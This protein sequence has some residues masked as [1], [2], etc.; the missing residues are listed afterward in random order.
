MK[1]LI[2]AGTLTAA[3]LLSGIASAAEYKVDHEGAHASIN[4]KIQHL[5]YSWLT[6]RFNHFSGDFNYDKDSAENSEIKVV[7]QI[8][9]LDSNHAERDK[10]L[11]GEKFLEADK[12]PTASFSSS[13]YQPSDANS[14]ILTGTLQLHGVSKSISFPIHKIGE[15]ADPWGGYRAGFSGT[16][17]LKLAD[18]GIDYDLG[19]ASTHV[20]MELHIEGVRQ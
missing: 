15:G 7:I 6:G 17:L 3:T 20:E 12:Y 11:K 10:H 8:A 14:G 4:F 5:G 2:I 1:K 16:T 19:P 13:H 9:S 18:Y